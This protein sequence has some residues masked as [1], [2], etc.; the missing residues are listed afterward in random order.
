[1]VRSVLAGVALWAGLTACSTAVGPA[2]TTR[3]SWEADDALVV[4]P[5]VPGPPLA[6]VWEPRGDRAVALLARLDPETLE[7]RAGMRFGSYRA[8]DTAASPD[9]MRLLVASGRDDVRVIDLRHMRLERT[10]DLPPGFSVTELAWVEG[11]VAIAAMVRRGAATFVRFDPATGEVLGTRR[12]EGGVFRF[13]AASDGVVVLAARTASPSSGRPGPVT[14]GAFHASGELLSA[15]VEEVR[16]GSFLPHPEDHAT[17]A[18][19][20]P[21][22][23]VRGSV[24]TVVGVDG[25]IA[26][27]DLTDMTHR[28]E[29]RDDSFFSALR[30]WAVPPAEAKMIDA[31]SLRAVWATADAL[32]VSGYRTDAPSGEERGF[33]ASKEPAG[34]VVIDPS[35]W[36]SRTIDEDGTLVTAARGLV[37]VS[38]DHMPDRD[39]GESIGLRAY[40]PSGKLV[41]HALGGAAVWEPVVSGRYA[42]LTFG[43]NAVRV[44][45]VD[46]ETG[47]LLARRPP[48][49][50]VLPW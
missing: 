5:R 21:A 39:R 45:A 11:D 37:L 15:E 50:V 7:A 2:P 41:W 40:D 29:G 43:W 35:D 46:L 34:V 44:H 1:M 17:A 49:L 31:T 13:A 38:Q 36:S 6:V 22:L 26:N 42:F 9:G 23:A 27:V 3:T 18:R 10:I 20:E 30:R 12:L 19:V 28:V 25:T 48:P 8:M 24:A 14:V 4:P 16:A 47:E 33:E 32:V